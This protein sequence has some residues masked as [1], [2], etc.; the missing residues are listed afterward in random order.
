MSDRSRAEEVDACN[1]AGRVCL[2]RGDRQGA[3]EQFSRALERF[4]K[5]LG[6]YESL[7]EE[8]KAGLA[9]KNIQILSS[10]GNG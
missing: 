3:F 5:A 7:G 10:R 4:R 6:L 1:Q 2:E 8:T 9:E